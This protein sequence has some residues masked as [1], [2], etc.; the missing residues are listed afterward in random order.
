MYALF[1]VRIRELVGNQEVIEHCDE[2]TADYDYAHIR[3]AVF[4]QWVSAQFQDEVS[5]CTSPLVELSM[6]TDTTAPLSHGSTQP[7]RMGWMVDNLD[8]FVIH[9]Y[10]DTQ[11]PRVSTHSEATRH[12]KARAAAIL[13]KRADGT[14]HVLIHRYDKDEVIGFVSRTVSQTY[15]YT[16]MSKVTQGEQ[17]HLIRRMLIETRVNGRSDPKSHSKHWAEVSYPRHFKLQNTGQNGARCLAA[18]LLAT[19]DQVECP[20]ID[21]IHELEVAAGLSEVGYA[22]DA[23]RTRMLEHLG[24]GC[25]AIRPDGKTAVTYTPTGTG[26][27]A[28]VAMIDATRCQPVVLQQ[29]VKLRRWSEAVRL[30][31]AY[32]IRCLERPRSY[33]DTPRPTSQ[34]HTTVRGETITE[35]RNTTFQDVYDWPYTP[36]SEQLFKK[37]ADNIGMSKTPY[38]H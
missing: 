32:G 18:A 7:E 13:I 15:G 36:K 9:C 26:W 35:I 5:D 23:D 19:K 6:Q 3:D 38:G 33:I 25:I 30:L 24:I 28:V 2:L 17:Q 12:R 27:Y 37:W 16:I 4:E 21:S 22:N 10:A 31:T 14:A 29:N 11:T 34:V 8:T 1:Q 20:S